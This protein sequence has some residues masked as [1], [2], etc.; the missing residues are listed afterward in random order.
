MKVADH[1]AD[2]LC[3]PTEI[4]RANLL[5]EGI[6]RVV[7]VGD[8]DFVRNR[9]VAEVY[10]SDL[11]VNAINWLVGEESFITIDRKLPRASMAVLTSQ[12]FQTFR[13][14]ALFVAPELILLIGIAIWWR[15]R[16]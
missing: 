13:Y 15:R 16:T 8:S 9:H 12:E 7:V 5:A 4:N 6:A 3:A 2:L 11:F 10:N 1:L 14:L